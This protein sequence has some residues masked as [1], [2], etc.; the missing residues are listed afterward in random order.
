MKLFG[1]HL[2]AGV[3]RD[4][5]KAIMNELAGGKRLLGDIFD[6]KPPTATAT[7][8]DIDHASAGAATHK[9]PAP[10]E[11]YSKGLPIN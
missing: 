3:L 8:T 1:E 5:I 10:R 7:A 4:P 2:R 11:R 6:K 9:Q